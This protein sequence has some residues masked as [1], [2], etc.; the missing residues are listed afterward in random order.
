[1]T[2]IVAKTLLFRLI[3]ELDR[4][5]K[6]AILLTFDLLLIPIALYG[7]F[8]LQY[9]TLVPPVELLAATPIYLLVIGAA[10]LFASALGISRVKLKAYENRAIASTGLLAILIAVFAALLDKV[11]AIPVLEMTHSATYFVFGVNFFLLSVL[12]R[13]ALLGFTLWIYRQ[14]VP[15][16]RVLIYGAGTTGVQLAAALKA[17]EM[18]VPVGFVDD[19]PA[20]QSLTVAGLPVRS[21]DNIRKIIEDSEIERVILA[22][23]SLSQAQRL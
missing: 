21:P 2:I 18:I 4:P 13:F 15:P 12:S 7:A 17:D 16:A 6:S 11:A 3:N 9:A 14:G 10:G 8:A 20:L 22:M 5:K 1:M 19:N 23:P